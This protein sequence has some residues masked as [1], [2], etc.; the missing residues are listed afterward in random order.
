MKFTLFAFAAVMATKSSAIQAEFDEEELSNEVLFPQVASYL[1][2]MSDEQLD[3]LDNYM[4]QIYAEDSDVSDSDIF[5]QVETEEENDLAVVA[6]YLAQL[7][8]EE[9][10]ELA[11]HS[12]QQ[13][14]EAF[15]QT[16]SESGMG[17]M[18]ENMQEMAPTFAQVFAR[19]L[20]AESGDWI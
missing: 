20:Q 15:A 17:E 1:N 8:S 5:A 3:Q 9:M 11:D 18:W 2:S 12:A 4:G 6:N 7:S 13:N 16:M 14:V 10:F 19:E